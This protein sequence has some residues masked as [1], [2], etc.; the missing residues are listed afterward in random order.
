MFENE[1]DFRKLVSGLKIDAEPN[2]A[3]RER[4]RRQMLET[5]EQAQAVCSVPVRA[6]KGDPGPQ[7]QSSA[8]GSPTKRNESRLGT[9]ETPYGVTTSVLRLPFFRLAIA[10]A[11]LIAATVGV[12]SFFGPGPVT[13][14]Q[15]QFATQKAPW[16]YAVVSR[17]Q[18]GEVRTERHWY[19]FAA[20]K[21]YAVL[22]DGSAVGW[23]YAAGP[24]KL[25]YSPRLKAL[26]IS[27]LS[28]P[29]VGAASTENLLTVFAVFAAKDDVSGSTSQQDGKTVRS[30][31]IERAEPDLIIPGKAVSLLKA[32]IMADPQTKHVVA[33][34]IEYRDGSGGVLAHEEWAMSYP[35]SGPASLYDLGVPASATIIDR[36]RQWIGTPG[37]GPTPTP[38]PTSGLG[39]QTRNSAFGVPFRLTPMEIGLPKPMFA[40][41]PQDV[42][43]LNL[44][45]PRGGPRPPFLAPVGTTN[46]ALGKPVSSSDPPPVIG[47]LSAITDGDKEAIDGSFVELSPGPQHVTIDLQERCE[48]YAVLVWHY[49]RWPRAYFDVVVQVSDDPAFKTTVKTIFN[50]DIDDSLGLGAGR[51]LSYVETY[52]GK[53]MEGKG[54]QGRYVRLFSN[55]NTHD[56]LNHYT[57]VEVYGR[58]LRLIQDH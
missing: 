56:D 21:A 33:A 13:F 55:G 57:E 20:Q 27:D 11:V 15:V 41:T 40:G 38:A 7:S 45:Q 31:E 52:E 35:Q 18:N 53:L 25:A 1:H 36:T 10:A 17:Y 16:L 49:H 24:K 39:S 23:D 29:G 4:L 48:I 51:D 8:I 58:P 5:F 2:P 54:A 19:N 32:T 12:W 42:R 22:D 26:T 14:H 46:V 30:F 6:S 43:T 50:N 37:D 44:E 3:H 28:A 9:Q 34:S 47:S